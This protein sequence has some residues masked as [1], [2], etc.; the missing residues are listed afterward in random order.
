V[1]ELDSILVLIPVRN[2]AATIAQVIQTLQ[3]AGLRRIRVVD[4]GSTDDSA[5]IARAAGAEVISEPTPGYG[6]A[7]WRGLQVLPED[8]D[9]ILFCDGDGSDDLSQLPEFLHLRDYYDL[10]LGDR[11]ALPEARVALTP[12]Q[13][14]G[15]G[16]ATRLIQLGWGQ[17][18]HDLGP[19]RLIRRSALEQ[20]DMQDRGF[21]WTV[22]MQVRAVELGLRYREIPVGYYPRQGGE[23]K[24]S[25]SLV[26]TLKASAGILGT[27]GQLYYQHISQHLRGTRKDPEF[28]TVPLPLG[29]GVFLLA[30]GAAL[31]VPYGDFRNPE[32]LWPFWRGIGV[33]GVGFVLVR[34][35][36]SLSPGWFW[37][38]TILLRL[39][40]LPMYPG[41]DIWRY[42]WEGY[43]QTLGFSPYHLPP[44]SPDLV[45][46]QTEWWNQIN[47]PG[48]TAIYPPLTQL[49][50]HLLAMVSP[51]VSLYKLSFI[52]A[53]ILV[54]WLLSRRYGYP[55]TLVYAWNPLVLYCFAG[56]G[57][58][59]SW[60][61]LPLVAAWLLFDPADETSPTRH[62]PS[63]LNVLLESR[64]G[65]HVRWLGS[66]LFLGISVAIKWISL[67]IVVFLGWQAWRQSGWK[68]AALVV[69][70]GVLPF[71]LSAIAFCRDATCPLVPT[72]SVFV[73][74]GRSAELFPYLLGLVWPATQQANWIYLIP[75]AIGILLLLRRFQRFQEFAEGYLIL[76]L[77]LS[78]IIHA[79]YFTW[80]IPFAVAS[81]NL[82]TQ[83]L[84]FSAF[85]YFL[86]PYRQALGNP[87][88]FLRPLERFL[89]WAPF[90]VGLW[91]SLRRS[92]PSATYSQT[93]PPSP[94]HSLPAPSSK[95]LKSSTHL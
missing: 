70:L 20:I 21:G 58:Y 17:V 85:V 65:Y 26:G 28:P 16:L 81:R 19:M 60:F 95:N 88:W 22:E 40:L 69:A 48:V 57:H 23:S 78:P 13:R 46:Y 62:I 10:V 2:E 39:L 24:I 41:D 59:D 77:M 27:L 66:A 72:S 1:T 52:L 30:L 93:T 94:S 6:Q 61:I 15:N 32:V 75:L 34:Q 83:L 76:L 50:F 73:A 5:A 68:L 92:P 53:D 49:G 80:L 91:W 33:M 47:H 89:L 42:L 8:V 86:L 82:G 44:N 64:Y 9:W 87:D 67:P 84:S 25:G 37:G 31:V 63:A 71:F 51:A 14:F 18:Y 36:R 11:S 38:V 90:L 4:N 56:G 7:C 35:V 29:L 54:C 79:W 3:A 74:Y 55:A 45:F 12:M 43:I